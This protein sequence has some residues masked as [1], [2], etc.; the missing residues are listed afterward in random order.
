MPANEP[1]VTDLVARAAGG[2][3][4]AWRALVARYA[5]L[6]WS[7]CRGYRLDEADAAD[8]SQTV[9]L[10]LVEQLETLRDPAALPGWL[11]TTTSRECVRVRM[12]AVRQRTAFGRLDVAA[13]DEAGTIDQA[14][15]AHERAATLRVAFQQLSPECQRLL[16]LLVRDPQP[17]YKEIS[18]QLSMPIGSIGPTRAR[19]L[20]RLRHTPALVALIAA[21]TQRVEGGEGVVQSVVER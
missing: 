12:A 16:E 10:R 8:V 18:A 14:L 13:G 9:W 15:L 7:V 21:E 2:D 6:V 17:S 5:A 3:E 11:V 1:S 4:R 19:C 20:D